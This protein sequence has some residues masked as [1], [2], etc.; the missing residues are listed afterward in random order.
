MENELIYLDKIV[1][2]KYHKYVRASH[3][4][5]RMLTLKIILIISK[6]FVVDSSSIIYQY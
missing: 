2:I 4:T 5:Y 1:L 6:H 3:K